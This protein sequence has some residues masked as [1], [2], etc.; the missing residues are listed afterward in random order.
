[1]KGLSLLI[2]LA[3]FVSRGEGISCYQCLNLRGVTQDRP[4]PGVAYGPGCEAGNLDKDFLAP[5]EAEPGNAPLDSCYDMEMVMNN[6]TIIVRECG[7]LE[8]LGGVR[9]FAADQRVRGTLWTV[10][11]IFE[12]FLFNNPVLPERPPADIPMNLCSCKG[13]DCNGKCTC[14]G[15]GNARKGVI[16]SEFLVPAAMIISLARTRELESIINL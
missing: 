2:F 7:N 4:F 13:D 11:K 12:D 10:L 15:T 1:M 6:V 9:C 16:I 14:G 3:G 5:C 8:E